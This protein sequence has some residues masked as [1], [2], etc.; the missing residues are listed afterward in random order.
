VP[1]P[2]LFLTLFLAGG[3]LLAALATPSLFPVLLL[4][5][6]FLFL[7]WIFHLRKKIKS[8]FIFI[9]TTTL[10]FGSGLYTLFDAHFSENSLFRFRADSYVDFYGTVYRSV[11]PGQNSDILFVKVNRI[12]HQ[13]REER[14][15]GRL[16]VTV[17][18]SSPISNPMGL[19]VGDKIKVSAQLT[20]PKEYRN[21]NRPY[22]ERWQKIQQI[23]QRAFTKSPLLVHKI[24]AGSKFYPLRSISILRQ[25]L[26]RNIEDFFTDTGE[27]PQ[28][29]TQGGVLEALL[30]GERGRLDE[31][32]SLA[33]QEAGLFHLFAI[34]GAHIALLS[35]ILFFVFR[36]LRIPLRLSYLLL[37]ILL[38][39][40][41][42]LVEG[43][44][45]IFRATLM[46][47]CFLSAKLIWREA[48]LMN[49]ISFCAFILLVINPFSL[50]DSGFQLTFTAT[51][52]IILFFPKV[53]K[54]LPKI[55]LRI[56]EILA[57]SL[58]AQLG[59]LP[60]MARVFNR[61]TFSSLFLNFAALPLVALIMLQGYLFLFLSFFSASLAS[62]AVEGLRI[63]IDGL[64]SLSHVLDGI[65][66][67]SY[68]TPPPH[69]VTLA[70]YYVFS[71]LLL[72]PLGSRKKLKKAFAAAFLCC[73]VLLIAYPF[74]PSS[75]ELK[76]TFIDVG[77]GD[78]ILVEFPGTKKML[79]DGGGLPLSDFNIGERV[80]SPFLWKKGIKAIDY[81]VLTHAHP[82]HMNGLISVAQNF[83][84]EEFWESLSPDNNMAY[85]RLRQN[86]NRSTVQRRVFRGQTFDINGVTVDILHPRKGDPR[87]LSV[88]NDQSSVLR[89][90][91]GRT[92]LLLASDIGVGAEADILESGIEVR[93]DV[94]KSPHHGSRS[95]SSEHF[96]EATNPQYIVISVGE[97]NRYGLP[98][99]EVLD[100]YREFDA[101]I[102]RTDVHGAIEIFSD[103]KSLR[104]RT[105]VDHLK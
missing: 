65:P 21:F 11:S 3:I 32:L 7:S 47:V 81:L 55:P 68:R 18:R 1:F 51:L 6:V 74:P 93:S 56:S 30:L 31:N 19:F 62:W 22:L 34:S 36:F 89:I 60:I 24:A 77:Q 71:A 98:D 84:I 43:R 105:A 20:I 87:I 75:K 91:F 95:S 67:L 79:I 33:L 86:L 94:L 80:V 88:D 96:L 29:T 78:S 13:N 48:N 46:T 12:T 16:Q 61:I 92:S 45:S 52:A 42:F 49:T 97:R 10:L 27:E 63:A 59:V 41:S 104:I 14:I 17:A 102:L 39:V 100:R 26:I 83:R 28:M 44:P 50:F 9:L 101:Q 8:T 23:H 38:I 73:F 76:V 69:M 53:M 66:F 15:K 70:G 99:Q 90:S 72:L 103:G 64:V 5:F 54:V 4:F 2:F 57:V 58:T 37:M 82:D 85:S 40:Y 25:K 35:L